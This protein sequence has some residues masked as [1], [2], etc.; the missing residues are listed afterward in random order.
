MQRFKT[1][2]N[3]IKIYFIVTK[4]LVEFKRKEGIF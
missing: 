2:F 4:T 1:F 3:D